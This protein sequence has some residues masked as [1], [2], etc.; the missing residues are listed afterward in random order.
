MWSYSRLWTI[1][2]RFWQTNSGPLE[3]LNRLCSIL[4]LLKTDII[5]NILI[6]LL[7]NINMCHFTNHFMNNKYI[8]GYWE[9]VLWIEFHKFCMDLSSTAHY[10]SICT[11][12]SFYL[13]KWY[14]NAYK[15]NLV[16]NHIFCIL[17]IFILMINGSTSQFDVF[18]WE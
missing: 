2:H 5:V 4:F 3:V 15:A 7:E 14:N 13:F 10:K 18:I 16:S 11:I 6:C 12:F 8:F 1:W 17:H 9:L